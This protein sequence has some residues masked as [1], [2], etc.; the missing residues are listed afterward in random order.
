MC[1]SFWFL[2]LVSFVCRLKY[3]V[4]SKEE[5]VDRGSEKKTEQKKKQQLRRKH[6]RHRVGVSVI[7][8][9]DFI[10]N[11]N[12]IKKIT[13]MMMILHRKRNGINE[14]LMKLNIQCVSSAREWAAAVR[15]HRHR[16]T[17]PGQSTFF[18]SS[19]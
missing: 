9:C 18:F 19:S 16:T 11:E 4:N 1:A 14:T 3:F 13:S 10:L 15:R 8:T 5:D 17:E 12:D 6:H 7:P 2:V